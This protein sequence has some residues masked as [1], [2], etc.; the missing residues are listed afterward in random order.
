MS[1]WGWL[2]AWGWVCV[3]VGVVVW[4]VIW[5]VYVGL[6]VDEVGWCECGGDCAYED[7]C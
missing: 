5:V 3:V 4:V 6:S 7:G 1:V 2:F